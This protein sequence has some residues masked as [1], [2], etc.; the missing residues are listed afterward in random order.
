MC[1][2][3]VNFDPR[4]DRRLIHTL[5]ELQ[6]FLPLDQPPDRSRLARRA[7]VPKAWIGVI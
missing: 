1:K 7:S 5:D 3:L 6:G 2:S 4:A